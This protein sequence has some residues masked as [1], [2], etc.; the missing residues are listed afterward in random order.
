[1]ELRTVNHA[2]EAIILAKRPLDPDTALK[3]LAVALLHIAKSVYEIER[4]QALDS[5]LA[6]A[7]RAEEEAL[8]GREQGVRGPRIRTNPSR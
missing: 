3:S 6:L 2:L 8:A 7:K 5:N 4:T 1:M